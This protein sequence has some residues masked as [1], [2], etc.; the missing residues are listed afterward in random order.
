VQYNIQFLTCF[1][2]RGGGWGGG[3]DDET[4]PKF[5]ESFAKILAKFY[6]LK[7]SKKLQ[8]YF[9]GY[10]LVLRHRRFH[11]TRKFHENFDP[12]CWLFKI[13]RKIFHNFQNLAKIEILENIVFLGTG[14][15]R[16][17]AKSIAESFCKNSLEILRVQNF[18]KTCNTTN[19]YIVTFPQYVF[20]K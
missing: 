6:E 11:F 2:G 8:H 18:T 14:R 17:I 3:D 5:A 1:F 10:C 9:E 12:K 19:T 4:F 7:I 15:R 16:K 13:F 20:K